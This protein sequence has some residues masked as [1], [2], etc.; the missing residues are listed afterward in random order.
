M[1]STV[2]ATD[3]DSVCCEGRGRGCED[4]EWRERKKEAHFLGEI[5][6]WCC[7]VVGGV[8][9]IAGGGFAI[10]VGSCITGSDLNFCWHP[11]LM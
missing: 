8:A 4:A 6:S 11:I 7:A 3:R 5:E 2:A 9:I 1:S 10:G